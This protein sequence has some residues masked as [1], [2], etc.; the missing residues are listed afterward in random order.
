MWHA[1]QA[2]DYVAVDQAL[3]IPVPKSIAFSDVLDGFDAAC[4]SEF[5]SIL[6]DQP[7]STSLLQIAVSFDGLQIS[8]WKGNLAIRRRIRLIWADIQIRSLT[9]T[10]VEQFLQK[11][12]QASSTSTRNHYLA[13]LNSILKWAEKYN[14][15]STLPTLGLRRKRFEE[16][17]PEA[18][19]A[20][21]VV[22]LYKHMSEEEKPVVMFLHDTGL[23]IG[24]MNSLLWSDVDLQGRVIVVRDN[25]GS[26]DF[27]TVPL[28]RRAT[29]ILYDHK[30]NSTGRDVGVTFESCPS[31]DVS[32]S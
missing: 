10:M 3:S 22:D 2:H 15:I 18:L 14:L 8:T 31:F 5:R 17:V 7:P 21:E 26:K 19:S 11:Q 25:K 9:P 12:E 29:A 32:L 4:P 16:H 30:K 13:T 1:L 27:R 24:E 20:Q 23:R 28:T 6:T